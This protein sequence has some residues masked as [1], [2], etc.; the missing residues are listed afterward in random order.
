MKHITIIKII[1]TVIATILALIHIFKPDLKVDSITLG[2]LV[3]AVLPWLAPIFKSVELPGGMKFE[4]QEFKE[5]VE[6]ADKAGMIEKDTQPVN[7]VEYTYQLVAK[8]DPK[9]ALA[10]LRI[11]LEDKLRKIALK[12]NIITNNK[13]LGNLMRV[14]SSHDLITNE[15]RAVLADLVGMLNAAVHS[16]VDKFEYSNISWALDVGTK[17]LNSLEK[18]AYYLMD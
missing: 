17:I 18:R 12:N 1:I 10:G 4:L 6:K 7:P 2:L 8:E 13:G 15:E 3:V 9:L 14:L 5:I 11:E 16:E